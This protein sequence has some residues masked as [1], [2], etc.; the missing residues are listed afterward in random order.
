MSLRASTR[1]PLACSGERYWAVPITCGGLRHR[2]GRVG[3]RAG[4]A[5]VHDLDVAVAGDHDVGRL[6]VA[7]DDAAAVAVVQ[8]AQDAVD[9]L[10]RA[11]RQQPPIGAQQVAQ[12]AA[13]DVLHHDVRHGRALGRVLARVVDRDDRGVVQRRGG[14]R[15][16][17]EPGLE[18][19]IAAPGPR[20]GS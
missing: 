20:G 12:R 13:V 11:L 2:R 7:V 1:S 9:Q 14:L 17:A 3:H 16:P 19:V 6:D 10:G 8:R 4:D 15:L 18:G 5:E